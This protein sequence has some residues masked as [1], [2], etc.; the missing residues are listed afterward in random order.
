M[1]IGAVLQS[2]AAAGS[3]S[4]WRERGGHVL[5]SCR[6]GR[7]TIFIIK[8]GELFMLKVSIWTLD[9]PLNGDEDPIPSMEFEGIDFVSLVS[10]ATYGPPALIAP[11]RDRDAPRAAVG[12][13]ILY[14][15]TGLVP[16]FEIERGED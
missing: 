6:S 11:A 7:Q 2:V 8:S 12:D 9:P 15:N 10:P 14:I 16:A 1:Q 13:R 5:A 3:G 4:G